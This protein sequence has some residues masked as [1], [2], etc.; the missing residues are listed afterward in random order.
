MKIRFKWEMAQYAELVTEQ[1]H[2][3]NL[4]NWVAEETSDEVIS[5]IQTANRAYLHKVLLI[6]RQG[7][8]LRAMP[9]V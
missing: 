3:I 8:D 2:L 5:S 6:V 1:Q 4:V 9:R 7:G